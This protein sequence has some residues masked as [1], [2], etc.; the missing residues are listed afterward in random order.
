MKPAPLVA[1]AL[2]LIGIAVAVAATRAGQAGPGSPLSA[3]GDWHPA[4]V[5]AVVA[6]FAAYALGVVFLA[7][8]PGGERTALALAASIQ[9]VPLAAPLLLSTDVDAYV[10]YGRAG[11]PYTGANP[12]VYGPLWSALSEPLSRIG[13]GRYAFRILAT[14]SVLALIVMAS[15]LAARKALAVAFIGWNPAVALHFAGGGHN[16]AFMM[17]L[18][19]GALVLALENRVRASGVAW[20]ASVFVKWSSG[21][22]YALW[23]IDRCRRGKRAGLGAALATA[24]VIAGLAF[25]LYGRA[26]LDVFSAISKVEHHRASLGLLGWLDDLGSPNRWSLRLS[27][28]LELAALAVFAFQAWRGR[29]RLGL[30]AGAL[31]I[32]GPRL[33]PWYVVWGVSLSAIDDEDRWGKV[34]AVVLTGLVL[35]DA[36]SSILAA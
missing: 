6:A 11:Q 17:V 8:Y 34:L 31:A 4:L 18:V 35:S 16:D 19:L 12:S 2:C 25:A 23:A 1:G 30:A 10:G 20:S 15:K 32:L 3:P 7:S 26:W 33:E 36:I 28:S 21:P 29:L 9:L 13:E 27:Q 22:L 14:C 5:V 24:I